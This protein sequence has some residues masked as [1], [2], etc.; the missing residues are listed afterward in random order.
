MKSKIINLIAD[1]S[2]ELS[3]YSKESYVLYMFP[4]RVVIIICPMLLETIQHSFALKTIKNT[5]FCM[6]PLTF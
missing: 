6:Q 1:H 4:I 5:F 3:A 2:F